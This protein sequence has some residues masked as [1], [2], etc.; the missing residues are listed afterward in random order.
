MNVGPLAYAEA[1]TTPAQK[2]L[3]GPDGIKKLADAFRYHKIFY[4]SQTINLQEAGTYIIW[5]KAV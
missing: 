4:E 1:F 5:Y 3:Y 2:M